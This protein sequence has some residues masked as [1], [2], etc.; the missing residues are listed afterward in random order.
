MMNEKNAQE[1]GFGGYGRG[2]FRGERDHARGGGF[3]GGRYF[4]SGYDS[5]RGF[6]GG[7]DSFGGPHG[8][9]LF[10]K[11]RF[12]KEAMKQGGFGRGFHPEEFRGLRHVIARALHQGAPVNIEETPESFVLTL[13]YPGQSKEA[14]GV[15]VKDDVLV[16]HYTA[17]EADS[18]RKYVHQELSQESFDR[19]FPLNGKVL[20]DQIQASYENGILTLVLP[21]N[22]ETN[23]PAQNVNVC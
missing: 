12:F 10:Q 4:T 8:E 6:G 20:T 7:R 16:I 5:G 14:F 9:H 11:L 23:Q 13:F 15:K 22:P 2:Q 1:F 17:P 3:G 21:K 19:S 18:T